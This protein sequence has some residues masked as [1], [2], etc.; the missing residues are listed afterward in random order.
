MKAYY[1]KISALTLDAHIW[2]S[3][4]EKSS[5]WVSPKSVEMTCYPANN[6]EGFIVIS[7][8]EFLEAAKVAMSNLQNILNNE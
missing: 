2:I 3:S 5:V 8:E 7:R 1:K 6:P 4:D